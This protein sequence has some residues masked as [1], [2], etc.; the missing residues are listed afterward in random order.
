MDP[1]Y[2]HPPV[3]V[4]FGRVGQTRSVSSAREA[5]ELLLDQRWP[6]PDGRK[7]LAARQAC[8]AVLEGLK[9][10]RHARKAFEAAAEEAD[11]LLPPLNT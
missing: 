5:A 1:R 11:I 3:R 6:Q 8:M 7:H 4:E 2:F 10:A 9:E